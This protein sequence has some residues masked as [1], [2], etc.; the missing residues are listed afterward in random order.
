MDHIIN[1]L[2]DPVTLPMLAK[3]TIGMAVIVGV[4][5]L[6]RRIHLPAVDRPRGIRAEH[7][8]ELPAG[9]PRHWRSRFWEISGS[10]RLDQHARQRESCP[11]SP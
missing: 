9:S 1:L 2:R 11:S 4:P 7:Q 5:I 8:R 10:A 3:F 6:C